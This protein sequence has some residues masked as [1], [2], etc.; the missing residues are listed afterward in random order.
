MH[1]RVGVEARYR[2]TVRTTFD[3]EPTAV[4]AS[5][6][7]W[8]IRLLPDVTRRVLVAL[9]VAWMVVVAGCGGAGTA[10]EHG[11]DEVASATGTPTATST[12]TPTP[13]LS[14][15]DP[16]SGLTRDGVTDVE[17][18]FLAHKTSLSD[19][20]ATVSIAFR[21]SVNGSGRDVSLLG[22]Y[23]PDTDRGWM[24][25]TFPDGVGTYY[26]EGDTT[27]ERVE[28]DGQTTYGTTDQVSAVPQ[29]PRFGADIRIREAI[30]AGSWEATGVVVNDGT[31]LLRYEA[32]E[33]TLPDS[34]T[35]DTGNT[36]ETR[37]ELLVSED[38][39]IHHVSIYTKVESSDGTVVYEIDVSLSDL[40]ST[41]VEEPDWIDRAE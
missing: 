33:V 14:A 30:E 2:G 7:K 35:A 20:A 32:T 11:T 10:T 1:N 27:Y 16:P 18:L 4:G 39:M 34:V 40:G 29:E 41:T 13:S 12:P 19:T 25:V 5:S 38:G 6:H 22:E 3:A 28:R 37:G 15:V 23:T 36:V 26:T 8:S 17:A 31:T 9:A 21:L 24:Q